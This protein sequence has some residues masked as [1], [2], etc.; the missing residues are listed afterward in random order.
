MARTYGI[1]LSLILFLALIGPGCKAQ[2]SN[3]PGVV[4]PEITHR[5]QTEV[6]A[7]Y[8]VPPQVTISI[9]G[10]KPSEVPGFELIVVTFSEGSHSSSHDFLLS[11]DRRT[12]AR[13]EK[14]DI[15]QDLMSKIAVQGRPVRG[16]ANAKVTI[17]NYD[18]FQCPFCSRM[19]QS[20]FP[21]LLQAYGDKV[22]FIYK[23]YPLVE[24]HPWAMHA[25]VNAN[26]LGEQN[27]GAYWDFADYVHA[28]QKAIAGR[29]HEEAFANLDHAAI[30]QATKHQLDLEKVR[31]CIKK[32]DDAAVRA[33]MAEGDKIGVD[34]TP[35]LFING[36][37]ISGV[38]PDEQLR[39]I[40]D[41]AL[42]DAG[43]PTAS[44]SSGHPGDDKK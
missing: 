5:I 34:S 2:N 14:I 12:L 37:R 17:I 13:L 19:H 15:S 31:A 25:A 26:C 35:T 29:S 20:L 44:S 18:D 30:E 4:S 24:I 7:R 40:V 9:S 16:N 3:D 6:R 33:S 36:E 21:G 43:E 8:N 22:R 42:A 39:A 32:Q 23:D 1:S 11:K 38:A 27:G 41:R 28:N 10:L